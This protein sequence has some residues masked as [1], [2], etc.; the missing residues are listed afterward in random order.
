MI[1]KVI[2]RIIWMVVGVLIAAA[3]VFT[4]VVS[5]TP[6]LSG[7]AQAEDEPLRSLQRGIGDVPHPVDTPRFANCDDCHALGARRTMP[8][9]HRT[10]GQQTCSLCH[11]YPA[12]QPEI[13]VGEAASAP[14]TFGWSAP[15]EQ[16]AKD[17]FRLPDAC[18]VGKDLATLVTQDG[19]SLRSDGETCV[20]CHNAEQADADVR[21]DDITSK[22]EFI[23]RG[24]LDRFISETSAK[25]DNLKRLFR[26]WQGRGAPD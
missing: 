20:A 3:L 1:N 2:A 13:A 16:A 18:A 22:Q 12:P 7:V 17:V 14:H 8:A 25:P 9:N 24:Y 5:Y 4:L 11:L 6:T 26:D 21:L 10:F 19:C 23:D 15:L